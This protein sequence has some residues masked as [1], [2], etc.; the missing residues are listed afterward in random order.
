M[1]LQLTGCLSLTEALL[2]EETEAVTDNSAPNSGSTSNASASQLSSAGSSGNFTTAMV[3]N[4]LNDTSASSSATV[5]VYM[6]GSDLESEYSEATTDLSEMVSATH[7]DSLNVIVQTMGTKK[8]DSQYGISSSRTERYRVT[9]SGLTLVDDSLS[10]L[11]CT[12]AATLLDFINWGVANYPAD[13]YI[14]MFWDH[15]GGPIY[16]FGYDEWNSDTYA[17]LTLDEIQLA[18]ASSGVKFDFIGMDC[19]I[20]SCLET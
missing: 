10:Q 17:A 12:A 16:G 2:E 20:M 9:S 6:N 8:W 3:R 5:L 7:T 1:T 13:R 19:C 11:D 14:L 15:G 18:L 4:Q